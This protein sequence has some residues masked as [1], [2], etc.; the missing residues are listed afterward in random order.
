MFETCS[1]FER[2][3]ITKYVDISI[4]EIVDWQL[5]GGVGSKTNF[6]NFLGCSEL[7][8]ATLGINFLIIMDDT[9]QKME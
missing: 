3:A 4:Y 7:R 8:V 5:A 9:P 1:L 2:V 6:F